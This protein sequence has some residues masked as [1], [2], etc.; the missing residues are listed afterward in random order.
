MSHVVTISRQGP[1]AV[2]NIDSPPVNALSQAVRSGLL[3]CVEQAIADPEV[4]AVVLICAG[5]TFIAGADISEFGKPPQA[6]FLPDVLEALDACPKPIIAAIH[7]TALGG[8][9]ETALACRYRIAVASARVGLPEVHLGLIP[10]AGGTQRLPRIAGLENALDMITS[11]RH[12]TA[13]EAV[14]M[15]V[16]DQLASADDLLSAAVEFAHKILTSH[17]SRP[18]ISEITLDDSPENRQILNHWKTRVSKKARG[19]ESPLAALDAIGNALSLPFAE[20]LKKEREIFLKCMS[21]PQSKALRHIFFAERAAAKLPD[22]ISSD[23][24]TI[25]TAAV[26]GGGTMGRGIAMCFAN[27]GIPV[28]VIETDQKKLQNALEAIKKTYTKMSVSGRINDQQR[29]QCLDQIDGSCDYTSLSEVDLVIE[30]AFEDLQVKH[31]IFRSLDK[32]CRA[33]AILAT[34]TSY[35]DIESIAAVVNDPSRVIGMHFFS[36]AHIMK[37]L[38][39]VRTNQTSAATITSMM[40]LGKN[41][42]KCTVL[43]GNGFGFAANRM[44]SAYGREGQQM[45]LEGVT[46]AQL[47]QAMK[48][49]GMA[50]GPAAVLDMS[51]IDIGFN[52]RKQNPNP[53]ADPGYFRPADLLAEHGYF[54]RKT[55]RGFYRYDADNGQA[56][57][58]PEIVELIRQEAQ[59]LGVEPRKLSENDIQQRMIKAIASEGQSILKEGLA[60]RASDL[61]VI[62]ING[63][64]FPRWRG[65]PMH[66][67]AENAWV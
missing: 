33:D 54:G 17:Q 8:G 16:I 53:P 19:Q 28:T 1:I 56:S 65:G 10:G 50:M 34:N 30:A 38:E 44:Y 45:L 20:G 37:L 39:V 4:Q 60:T 48:S 2:I 47:D 21:S 57:E 13:K 23:P 36:P 24:I 40:K 35:L 31:S 42:G 15:G 52:A 18:R 12:V 66:F 14:G 9:L 11:G 46:P 22:S 26:I 43:V 29:Q 61:D 59:R 63:Y 58:D 27:R 32:H 3:D 5:R 51:G 41:L 25:Q 67:A 6:T 55:G 49:W 64:G 62:W 7:G